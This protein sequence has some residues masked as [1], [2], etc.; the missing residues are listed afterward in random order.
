[1]S[2][3]SGET[4]IGI[5]VPQQLIKLT[6]EYIELADSGNYILNEEGSLLNDDVID[7][8]NNVVKLYRCAPSR[9]TEEFFEDNNVIF[10]GDRKN[11]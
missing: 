6:S 11:L 2:D 1:M 10:F 4:F 5:S 3:Q 9:C 7:R 8:N